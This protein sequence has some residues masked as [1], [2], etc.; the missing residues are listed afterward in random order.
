MEVTEGLALFEKA[1]EAVQ[2]LKHFLPANL[3]HP[4]VGVICGSGLG[5][6]ADAVNPTHQVEA[7]YKNIPHFP[8]STGI[9]PV[10][11]Y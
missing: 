4:S 7:S 1:T 10:I 3:Q 9:R 8:K 6:L 5:S 11:G 2:Y